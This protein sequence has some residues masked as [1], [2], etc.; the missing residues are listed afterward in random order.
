MR[1]DL[2]AEDGRLRDTSQ[3]LGS[4]G[5]RNPVVHDTERDNLE[6]KSCYGKIVVTYT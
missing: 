1:I 3:P 2:Q 4:A 5:E 6:R